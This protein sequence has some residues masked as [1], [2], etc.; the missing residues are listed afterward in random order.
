VAAGVR[1]IEAVTGTG[2]DRLVRKH[3]E[4]LREAAEL[5]KSAPHDIVGNL[6]KLMDAHKES[7]R[8]IE[9]VQSNLAMSQVQ[10]LLAKV[11]SVEGIQFLATEVSGV[12]GDGL[13]EMS[14]RIKDKIGSGVVVLGCGGE[15]KVS[16]VV[17]VTKDLTA[18]I[19][20]SDLVK[21]IA[22]VT[23]GGGGG[24]PDFA[25]AGGKMPE[26]IGEAVAQ[27]PGILS[28]LLKRT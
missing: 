22:A 2:A 25:Q 28:Q 16:W 10:D 7:Q 15:G 23:G 24:R 20:A 9:Q 27:A 8:R 18:R 5:L 1:R 12:S 19:S 13:R 6:R 4:T 3:E 17:A 26:K 14:D 11:V 21:K